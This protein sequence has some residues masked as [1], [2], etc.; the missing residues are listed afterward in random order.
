MS[1]STSESVT[2]LSRALDQVGELLEYVHADRLD[3][4]TP[5]ADWDLGELADHIVAAPASFLTLLRGEQPDWSAPTPHLTGGWAAQFRSRAD[6]LIHAWHRVEGEAPTPADMQ[7]AEFAVHAWDLATAL[8]RDIRELDT[9]VAERALAYLKANL[10]ADR[11]GSVF[12]AELP[13]PEDADAYTRL[14]AFAGR[15]IQ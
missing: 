4:P 9:G 15:E 14:A 12:A 13:A 5:C 10:T 6:D 1:T 3:A 2:A 8:D 11:R 7:V